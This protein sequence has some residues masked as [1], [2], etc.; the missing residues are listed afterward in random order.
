MARKRYSTNSPSIVNLSFCD[1]KSPVLANI[2]YLEKMST[3][4]L[5]GNKLYGSVPDFYEDFSFSTYFDLSSNNLTGTLP[6][7]IQNL[8]SLQYFDI[9]GNPFM[10]DEND[11]T[12]NAYQ[13]DSS[14][15]ARPPEADNFTCPE[16]RLTFNNGLIRLEPTFYEYKYCI[17]DTRFYGDKGL[18]KQCMKDGTCHRWAPSSVEDLRP[19]IMNIRSGYWPSPDP[20]NAESCQMS[21]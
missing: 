19:S 16:G 11:A 2:L 14:K 7:G 15:T 4:D 13:P 12:S 9:S 6:A 3:C 1:I 17:C 10:R 20:A 21:C 8:I 18:C 5:K